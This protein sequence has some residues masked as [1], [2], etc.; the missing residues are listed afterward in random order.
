MNRIEFY[1][2]IAAGLQQYLPLGY[3]ECPL[4]ISEAILSERKY[5]LLL[6]E[7]EG[8]KNMPVMSLE[9]YIDR[10]ESGDDAMATLIDIAVDYF[11][12]V[13]PPYKSRQSQ[14][15]EER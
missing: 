13:K 11:K 8:I 2:V 5:A 6:L 7:K 9:P 14:A 10:V 3:Q 15:R 1:Q 4:Y 12:M